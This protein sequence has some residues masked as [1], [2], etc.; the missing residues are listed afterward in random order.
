MHAIRYEIFQLHMSGNSLHLLG[1]SFQHPVLHHAALN[2]IPSYVG[3][4]DHGV[5]AVHG[6]CHVL[7]KTVIAYAVF[8][9]LLSARLWHCSVSH[10]PE[11]Q[12]LAL[13]CSKQPFQRQHRVRMHLQ[14]F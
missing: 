13:Q 1:A 2:G 5:A 4:V 6:A 8:H 7:L 9:M 12:T 11:C 3:M 14:L 10:A